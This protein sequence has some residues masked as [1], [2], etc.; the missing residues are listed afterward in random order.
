MYS[1]PS[2][3]PSSSSTLHPLHSLTSPYEV[4]SSSSSS[5]APSPT[6]LGVRSRKPTPSSAPFLSFS[7]SP[8][9]PPFRPKP[10]TAEHDDDDTADVTRPSLR[11]ATKDALG[12]AGQGSAR[13]E[14]DSKGKGKQTERTRAASEGFAASDQNR[15][16]EV[17]VHKV[18]SIS[19]GTYHPSRAVD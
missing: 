2:P 15:E 1:A 12:L 11:K 6:N 7:S 17:V 5:R 19:S 10:S 16:R 9:P 4:P 13:R 18:G 3:T 14:N 8:P